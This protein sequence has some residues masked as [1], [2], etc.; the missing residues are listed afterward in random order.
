MGDDALVVD[1]NARSLTAP[2]VLLDV[3]LLLPCSA[4][5][6]S[7]S[8]GSASPRHSSFSHLLWVAFATALNASIWHLNP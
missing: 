3:L 7:A 6:S 4:R 5:T 2:E 8:G 1:Q